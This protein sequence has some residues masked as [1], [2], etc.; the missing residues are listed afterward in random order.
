M[1]YTTGGEALC[2]ALEH[3]GV[4]H[5]FGLPGTQNIPLFEA[6]RL[7]SIRTVLATHE[8]AAG[9]MAN[10]YYRASGKVGV[11]TTI[12]GPGF[13]YTIPAI[14]EAAHDSAALMYIVGKPAYTKGRE[15]NLQAID[16]RAILA[17]LVKRVVEVDRAMDMDSAVREAYAATSTGEPG[18]VM[19]HVDERAIAGEIATK[20]ERHDIPTRSPQ[21]PAASGVSQALQLLKSSKRS[22]FFLGQGASGAAKQIRVFA[23]L[24]HIPV[25]ATRSARGILP[26]DH[27][28]AMTFDFCEQ[29]IRDL[30]SLLD[31]SDL[32]VCIGCKLCHNGTYGFQLHLPQEKLIH[33]DASSGVL[34]ANYTTRL[35]ICSDSLA[36]FDALAAAPGALGLRRQTWTDAELANVRRSGEASNLP[37][38][39]IGG[40]D[41]RTPRSFF[42]ELRKA[43]P[44]NSCLVTDSGLHQVLATRYYRV[45]CPRGLMV[46]TDFQSMGFGLPAAIGAKLA[47]PDK[48]VVALIGDGGLAMSGMEIITAVREQ[49]PITV[50]VFND[51]ALGQIRAQQVSTFGHSHATDLLTPDL[52][53]FAQAVGASYVYLANDAE[54]VL[55]RV[56]GSRGVTLVEV[57]VGDSPAMRLEQAKGLARQTARR[58]LPPASL[59]W[60][61]DKVRS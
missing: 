10:G 18:P 26:E 36:F 29:G 1:K 20:R 57:A 33:V 42:S 34:N 56:I 58:F 23:E 38:P 51:G 40:V 3:L 52:A 48:T 27:L 43:L 37:E 59:R 44:D 16:Q 24:L 32:I 53:L 30:N 19:L 45:Q 9:F 39:K 4:K 41:R 55:R 12:P 11:L 14:A 15:F 60:I 50:I 25:I 2:S 5:I 54:D 61:R 13:A 49:I 35:S 22:A 47:C 31:R 6:L 7:S 21:T 8:L 46:P 17:P 28:L